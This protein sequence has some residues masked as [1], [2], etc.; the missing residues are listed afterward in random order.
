MAADAAARQSHHMPDNRDL[1]LDRSGGSPSTTD[2]RSSRRSRWSLLATVAVVTA[3]V[4]GLAL[5]I[6]VGSH[7]REDLPRAEP[8]DILVPPVAAD[9]S[10]RAGTVSLP[11]QP[12][13]LTVGEPTDELP[14]ALSDRA[15]VAPPEDG[16]LVPVD[17]Q[18]AKVK[19]GPPPFVSQGTPW[20][21][22]AEVVLT[23]DGKEYPLD[24]PDGLGVSAVAP[25]APINVSRWVAV[26]G[27][28]TDVAVTVTV[29]GQQQTVD[30]D[31]DVERGK[32]A[33]LRSLPSALELAQEQPNSCGTPEQ[34][35]SSTA[36]IAHSDLPECELAGSLRMPFVDGLGWA[37][38][39]KEYLVVQ[40]TTDDW[41]DIP[42]ESDEPLTTST[43]VAARL[44]TARPEP[45]PHH[46]GGSSLGMSAGRDSH[47][48]VFEVPAGEP[49]TDLALRLDGEAAPTDPFA[50]TPAQR[51]RLEWTIS[52]QELS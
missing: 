35:G 5:A 45:G 47:Q 17:F 12:M 3:A 23:A 29:D 20:Q 39:G 21:A 19:G 26:E 44:G 32:A 28:P 8:G 36:R 37:A 41:V 34:R 31:G 42:N 9:I 25:Q 52:G 46:V 7:L 1:P 33:Q 22:K 49:A 43:S 6:V 24:G 13:S 51:V 27:R 15:L 11:W 50:S 16:S 48:F 30:T 14:E 18:P 40:V 38:K 10:S 4:L 2:E